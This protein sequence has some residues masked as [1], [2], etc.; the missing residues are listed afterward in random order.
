MWKLA[1]VVLAVS[2]SCVITTLA[3]CGLEGQPPKAETPRTA[4]RPSI[5]GV[6]GLVTSGHP[7]ASMAGMQVLLKG[8]NAIDASVAVLAT[9]NVVRPQMSGAGGNGF[10]TIYEKSTGKVYSL[11]ATG[12]APKALNADEVTDEDLAKGIKAGAVPG[13][14]GGWVASL[15][16]FGTMSLGELLQPAIDYAENGHPI[17][18]SVVSSIG[19][20]QELFEKFGSSRAAFFPQG[21]MPVANEK[22]TKPGLA[23]TFKKVV[24]A[25]RAALTKGKSRS[26]ALQAAFDRF[27]K[28]D[29]AEEVI[30]FYKE[31]G[32]LFTADDLAGYEPIWAEPVHTTYRGYDVYSSPSTSRGGLEVTMQLNLIEGFDLKKLGHNS[33]EVLHL[34]AE[35]IK[36]AKA[37]VY[38]YVADPK[39]TDLPVAGMLSK[40]YAAERRKL[41]DVGKAGA[42]PESGDPGGERAGEADALLASHRPA[43]FSE[44]ID[45]EGHTDSFS[46]VDKL[47]N[48]VACTPTHGSAFG[49]GVVVGNTGLTFNNG[50]RIGSTAPYPDHVNYAR[51]GQIPILNNSPI[52]VLKDGRFVLAIGT[53]GGETIGQTQFQAVVNVLDFGMEI[54]EAIAAPRLAV[55]AD[56][57][58]YKPGSAMKLQVESRIPE[59]VT[60]KLEAMGHEVE[61]IDGYT[62]GSMQGILYDLEKGT[63]AAGADPRRVAYAVGW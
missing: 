62:I 5:P 10:M 23:S 25:E 39:T 45:P 32:G 11:N 55:V 30:R 36:V 51:G 42:Y 37:D 53:P 1:N 6:H 16:R 59:E 8:G 7:L 28:G 35:S 47:G 52:I 22:V 13:L 34:V 4:H 44:R 18:E 26:E 48:A 56:P 3:G 41:I 33:P 61:R 17:A 19:D 9:L 21:R 20:H 57:S 54:Q 15:E 50:T 12:A 60:S 58:F 29:I 38:R 49:T 2:L 43:R 24:E 63:M 14:F 46:I 40:Q 27:Y 31:H